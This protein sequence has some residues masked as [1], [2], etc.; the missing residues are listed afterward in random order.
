MKP[1]NRTPSFATLLQEFFLERL[2]QQRNASAQTV[3]AYRDSFRLLLLFAQR[4]S[5]KPPESLNLTDLDAPLVLAFL[6]HLES[7]APQQHPQP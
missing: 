2:V 7:R 5:C 4:H 1:S 6:K 3:A